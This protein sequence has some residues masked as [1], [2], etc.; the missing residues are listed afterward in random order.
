MNTKFTSTGCFDISMGNKKIRFTAVHIT[1]I[2][3]I[4]KCE[5]WPNDLPE[6]KE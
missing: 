6:R 3:E 5:G 4:F 1:E 2:R